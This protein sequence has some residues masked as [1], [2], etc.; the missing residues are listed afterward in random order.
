MDSRIDPSEVPEN[1]RCQGC[2]HRAGDVTFST[3]NGEPYGEG[4]PVPAP[5]VRREEV[6]GDGLLHV[7]YFHDGCLAQLA[8]DR[9]R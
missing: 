1:V 9:W 2:G 5:T 4:H 8:Y 7:G 6:W 3:L